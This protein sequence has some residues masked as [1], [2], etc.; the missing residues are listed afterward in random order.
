MVDSTKPNPT[1]A[2]L[3]KPIIAPIVRE[4]ILEVLAEFEN[5]RPANANDGLLDRAG[6]AKFLDVSTAQI[7]KLCREQALPFRRCG[8]VKRFDRDELRAWWKAQG[9]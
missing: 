9:K 6:A 5:G 4:A 2:E 7:D 1:L 8:D 3:L